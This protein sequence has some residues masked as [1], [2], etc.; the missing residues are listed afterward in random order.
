MYMGAESPII[1]FS[2]GESTIT[3]EVS[4]WQM[5]MG[6]SITISGSIDPPHG[7]VGVTLTYTD[8]AD[9]VFN[10][11]VT[12]TGDGNYSDTLTPG[13]DRMWSVQASWSG[14]VD[15]LSAESSEVRFLVSTVTEVT[16]KIWQN[17]TFHKVF[18]PPSD[19]HYSPMFED[20]VWD[21]NITSPSSINFTTIN[22]VF[23]YHETIPGLG[24]TI[25]SY[26]VTYDIKVL[27]DTAEGF[28]DV[29]A[30]FDISSQSEFWPYT[31]T[32][33]FRYE[34]RCRVNAVAKYETSINLIVPP[35]VKL[36]EAAAVSGTIVP[37]GGPPIEGVNVTLSYTR[38]DSSIANRTVATETGGSFQDAYIPDTLGA[39][40]L[41]ASWTGDED[42][43]GTESLQ[44]QFDVLTD[45]M[46]QVTWDATVYFIRTLSNSTVSDF[47]F[48]GTALQISFNVSGLPGT[49]GF[50]NVTTPK[51]LLQGDPWTITIDGTPITNSIQTE[52]DTH[53]FLYFTYTHSS[54]AQ[55]IIQGTWI[56]PEFPSFIILPL[57]MI[58]T[59]LA[60]TIFRRRT[61]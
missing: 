19:H 44:V 52:N 22:G 61:S 16:I 59:L 9:A 24:G 2:V 60:V 29:T 53:T 37:T 28:Y 41:R 3:C 54:T 48:N 38:P 25:T 17:E 26:N 35:Q 34:L 45:L 47:F 43:N 6:E 58:A 20:I 7:G 27:E 39:W 36:G 40:S 15:T 13:L 23:T 33:L 11:T 51:N 42:H 32:F 18:Q 8:P 57:F 12:T 10:R 5:Y 50:C 30:Y 21:E 55:I 1:M 46:H 31:T 49:E 4:S 14:D 56:I